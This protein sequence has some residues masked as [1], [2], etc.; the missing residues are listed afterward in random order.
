M[1]AP[2]R[3][4]PNLVGIPRPRSGFVI[5]RSRFESARQLR[6]S[7]MGP[8]GAVHGHRGRSLASV[9]AREERETAEVQPRRS[10]T[11]DSTP[12]A[13]G[14]TFHEC[15]RRTRTSVPETTRRIAIA[16][17]PHADIAGAGNFSAGPGG[18]P[19]ASNAPMVQ[20]ALPR[21]GRTKPRWSRSFTGDSPQ[22]AWLPALIAGLAALH[23]VGVPAAVHTASVCVDPPL[24]CRSAGS[25]RGS[26]LQKELPVVVG[27]VAP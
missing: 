16:V 2:G 12:L 7:R 15:V 13:P 9:T 19:F 20:F 17:R 23:P 21:P 24:S 10:S 18:S 26:V 8:T 1:A 27:Q 14:A 11:A 22:T 25:S 6:L 4:M 3:E 5:S